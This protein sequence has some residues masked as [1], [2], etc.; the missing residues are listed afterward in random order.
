ME[1]DGQ[2][3][4]PAASHQGMSWYL[5]CRSLGVPEVR[6]ERVRN[7]A[8]TGIRTPG[9]P[10]VVSRCTDYSNPVQVRNAL[11]NFIYVGISC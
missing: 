6:S 7:L 8:S 5:L 1:V 9:R 4:A 2:R 3:H 10:A 11:T